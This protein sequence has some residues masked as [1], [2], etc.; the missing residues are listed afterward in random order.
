M[1]ELVAQEGELLPDAGRGTGRPGEDRQ[2]QPRY[3][4]QGQQAQHEGEQPVG[5]PD[6][7]LG[8]GADRTGAVDTRP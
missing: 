3:P 8:H 4:A 5:V 2:E 1:V 6:D 7:P